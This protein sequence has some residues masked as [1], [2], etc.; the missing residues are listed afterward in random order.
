LS[1]DRRGS[2]EFDEDRLEDM[3]ALMVLL[4]PPTHPWIKEEW[5][6]NWV[7]LHHTPPLHNK[8]EICDTQNLNACEK[9][10]WWSGEVCGKVV[11]FAIRSALHDQAE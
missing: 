3:L 4:I 1:K 7:T 10:R 9:L 8:K 11:R 6:M 2:T 5:G